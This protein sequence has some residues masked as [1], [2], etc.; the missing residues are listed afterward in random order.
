MQPRR[1]AVMVELEIN[2]RP[3]YQTMGRSSEVEHANLIAFA[4]MLPFVH[5]QLTG[6]NF[7]HSNR[8]DAHQ[9]DIRII[10]FDEDES[11]GRH[12]RDVAL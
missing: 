5:R 6:G 11:P 9:A 1:L 3:E 7:R 2:A 4:H 8:H 10:R 12:G